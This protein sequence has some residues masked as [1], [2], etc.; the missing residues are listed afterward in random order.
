MDVGTN[1]ESLGDDVK[2]GESV[3]EDGV[4]STGVDGKTEL[5]KLFV[6]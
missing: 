3:V 6:G 2:D 1:E 5:V 4:V